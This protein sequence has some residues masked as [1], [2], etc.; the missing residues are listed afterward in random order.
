MFSFLDG[1]TF[2]KLAL[3]VGLAIDI[4][5]S[6]IKNAIRAIRVWMLLLLL[7]R[8]MYRDNEIDSLLVCF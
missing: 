8:K 4:F 3:V 1:V 5:L 2:G 7:K 6:K